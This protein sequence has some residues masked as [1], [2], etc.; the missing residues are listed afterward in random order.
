[1]VALFALAFSCGDDDGPAAS[2][3][4]SSDAAER[5]ARGTDGRDTGVAE[6][7]H[8]PAPLNECNDPA[9]Q[10]L[11]CCWEASNAG[12]TEKEWAIRSVAIAE[13]VGIA[14]DVIRTILQDGLDD[15]DRGETDVV[16]LLR[17]QADTDTLVTGFG[18]RDGYRFPFRFSNRGRGCAGDRPEWAPIELAATIEGD[19]LRSEAAA[20]VLVVP[21][22]DAGD[23]P[24]ELRVRHLR[25]VS[26]T[27]TEDATC[28]GTRVNARRWAYGE[29]PSE[30]TGFLTVAD[31]SAQVLGAAGGTSLCMFVAGTEC[32][33]DERTWPRPPN[34]RCD[35]TTCTD[36]CDPSAEP[37]GTCNA[38]RF[39]AAFA[40]S[41]VEIE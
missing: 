1:M 25:L 7:A 5:D 35:E 2:A 21:L 17:L 9:L 20:D 40:A 18:C 38:W 33:G 39:A 22:P 36:G 4:A 29:P 6:D 37:A 14:N 23:P 8:V 34:A 11:P 19:V 15:G 28:V 24:P 3:D 26:A 30:A 32:I 27:L 12:R 41:G 31:T 13:P 10:R 16:W